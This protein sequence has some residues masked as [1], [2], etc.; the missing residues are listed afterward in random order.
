MQVLLAA[1]A[2][3]A[4]LSPEFLERL[5]RPQPR[6]GQPHALRGQQ[7]I[8]AFLRDRPQAAAP[9]H[10]EQKPNAMVQLLDHVDGE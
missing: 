4:T 9:T 5:A 1:G 10:I 8:L 2:S 6:P 7:S 3:V